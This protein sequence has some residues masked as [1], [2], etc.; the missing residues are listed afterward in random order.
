MYDLR[1]LFNSLNHVWQQGRGND[2]MY[3]G[4]YCAK[5]VRYFF[6]VRRSAI[7][8][9]TIFTEKAYAFYYYRRSEPEFDRDP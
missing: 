9:F 6:E 8:S 5:G 1:P 4:G 3:S 2:G 7:R